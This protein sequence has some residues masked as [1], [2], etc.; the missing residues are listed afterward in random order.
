ME[1]NDV[2]ITCDGTRL[3]FETEK[4]EKTLFENPTRCKI[5]KIDI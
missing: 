1:E 3:D 2:K 5:F 4:D